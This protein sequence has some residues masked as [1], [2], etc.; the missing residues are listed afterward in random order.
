MSPPDFAGMYEEHFS[1]TRPK[2]TTWPPWI[3]GPSYGPV[4]WLLHTLQSEYD[5]AVASQA[6]HIKKFYC[7]LFWYINVK[8]FSGMIFIIFRCRKILLHFVFETTY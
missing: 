5:C 2:T 3:V 6:F 1:K 7:N 4:E 8:E